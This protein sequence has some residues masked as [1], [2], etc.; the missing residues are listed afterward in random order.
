MKI[1][2]NSLFCNRLRSTLLILCMITQ[3]E[4]TDGFTVYILAADT[5]M[6][7]DADADA[8]VRISASPAS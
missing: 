5:S 2:L 4:L 7:C 3:G 6:T 1:E 8:D